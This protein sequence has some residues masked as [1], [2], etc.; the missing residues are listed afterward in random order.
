MKDDLIMALLLVSRQFCQICILSTWI[1]IVLRA[2]MCKQTNFYLEQSLVPQK[3]WERK[4]GATLAKDYSL[5]LFFLL[6]SA[7]SHIF[8]CLDVSTKK[9]G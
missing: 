9:I 1:S 7:Q 3:L 2:I 5:L 4:L 8:F 6:F